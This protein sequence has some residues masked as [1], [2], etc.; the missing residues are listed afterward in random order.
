M[1]SI[2]T[3]SIALNLLSASASAL[4][5]STRGLFLLRRLRRLGG[6]VSALAWSI[7]GL[8][9]LRRLR[10][11][12]GSVHRLETGAKEERLRGVSRGVRELGSL[13][14]RGH[15]VAG[16]MEWRENGLRRDSLLG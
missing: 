6:S 4:A 1:Q 11:L 7:K 16:C 5:W 13:L 8:L 9:L 15:G 3:Q 12:D 2:A 10:R 14:G